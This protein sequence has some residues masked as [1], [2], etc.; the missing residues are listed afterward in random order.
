[1]Q[2]RIRFTC[3][4]CGMWNSQERLNADHLPFQAAMYTSQGLG[5]GKGFKNTWQKNL[6]L[7]GA[8]AFFLRRLAN[9]LRLI[10]DRLE[11]EALVYGQT[12]SGV[13]VLETSAS[14]LP[15]TRSARRS[16]SLLTSLAPAGVLTR[17]PSRLL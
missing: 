16:E 9:K 3:P 2:P 8:K 4:V 5:R 6:N 15:S 12:A 10:A 11:M 14:M 7:T 13:S 1:M 17:T